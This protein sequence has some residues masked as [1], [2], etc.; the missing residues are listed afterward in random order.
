MASWTQFGRAAGGTFLAAALLVWWIVAVPALFVLLYTSLELQRAS[1]LALPA[2][3]EV[4]NYKIVGLANEIRRM[5]RR[6]NGDESSLHSTWLPVET[7]RRTFDRDRSVARQELLNY[8]AANRI[9]VDTISCSAE[10]PALS[11]CFDQLRVMVG[12]KGGVASP[13]FEKVGA[14]MMDVKMEVSRFN[15]ATAVHNNTVDDWKS[16]QKKYDQLISGKDIDGVPGGGAL[17]FTFDRLRQYIPIIPYIFILPSGVIVA[18]FSGLMGGIGGVIASLSRQLDNASVTT[19]MATA[20]V[21]RPLLGIL[22][23]SAAEATSAV[24]SLSP[25]ALA[26]LG[27]FAGLSSEM[28]VKWLKKK[29]DEFFK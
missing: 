8:A 12:K 2:Q 24:N 9:V 1:K 26:S 28:A 3:A 25:P 7:E 14:L 5:Q 10:W 20:Y 17:A 29:A 13:S 6:I 21:V 4:A 27:V 16:D 23:G 11:L 18:F 15:S 19:T 22:A